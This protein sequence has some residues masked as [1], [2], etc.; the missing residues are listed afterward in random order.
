MLPTQ[1]HMDPQVMA[2]KLA[3][4]REKN[5]LAQQRFRERRRQRQ[6]EAGQQCE[7]L[8]EEIEQVRCRGGSWVGAF[9]SGGSCVGARYWVAA[10]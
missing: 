4:A 10:G 8:Q 1:P 3:A 5:R 9:I 6:Q 2:A 7:V